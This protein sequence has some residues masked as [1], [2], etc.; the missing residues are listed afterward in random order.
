ML[1]NELFEKPKLKKLHYFSVD[2]IS[3][4]EELGLK[5]DKKSAWYLAQYNTSGIGFNKKFAS[6]V[7]IF[8]R[9]IKTIDFN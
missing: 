4:A 3:T 5:Q 9:P 7:R 2:D 1:I 8:G 6:A